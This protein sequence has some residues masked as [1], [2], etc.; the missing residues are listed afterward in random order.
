MAACQ[1]LAPYSAD[2]IRL[3]EMM[4]AHDILMYGNRTVLMTV[5]DVP[6]E[7][8]ETSGV[9]GI[10]SVKEIIAHLASFEHILVDVFNT[11]QGAKP[12]PYLRSWGESG[13]RFNDAQVGMRQGL[14][15]LEVLNE[16]EK[17][18]AQTM[19]MIKQFQP[20]Q[21]QEVGAIPWY[22][23]EYSLDDL[24][25]YAFYGHKR[26][27]CSQINEFKDKLAGQ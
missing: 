15:W 24:I 12:G 21:L 1:K 13:Q 23:S 20:E 27:H 5:K 9:C 11:F 18:Q 8:W 2:F 7:E 6:E 19:E 25:V 26:E 3:E 4:N 22:G 17:I 10:W 16:Y 14:S